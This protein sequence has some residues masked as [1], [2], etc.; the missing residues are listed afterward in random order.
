M[1]ESAIPDT[2][3]DLTAWSER[4]D[5]GAFR[6]LVEGHADMVIAV[7]RRR[8]GNA[9]A[10]DDAAQA[11]FI[12]LA[13]RAQRIRDSASLDGWLY[14]AAIGVCRNARR[15]AARRTRH[16]R[17]AAH[18][19]HQQVTA[20]R[21]AAPIDWSEFRPRLDE[22]MT[23]LNTIE[24]S[25]VIGHFLL[26]Q[27]QAVV[28]ERH[29]LSE[30]AVRRRIDTALDK[31][32]LWF[33]RRELRIGT[34]MLALCLASE[35]RSAEPTL[36]E[37]CVQAGLRP[38]TASGASALASGTVANLGS[39]ALAAA[40][41][42]TVATA[43]LVGASRHQP[44]PAD[45]QPPAAMAEPAQ[46]RLRV[47]WGGAAAPRWV[48]HA[49]DDAVAAVRTE[50]GAPRTD[51]VS[52]KTRSDSR[53]GLAWKDGLQFQFDIALSVP[54]I[55]T[56]IVVLCDD[57]GDWRMN[58]VHRNE[59]PA[60]RTGELSVRSEDFTPLNRQRNGQPEPLFIQNIAIHTDT[61]DLRLHAARIVEVVEPDNHEP[62]GH[63][64]P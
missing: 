26:G 50:D 39:I 44:E 63:T 1:V 12:L 40:A 8:L 64:T 31:L 32:R 7:C 47:L 41:V 27:S 29:G 6:R 4:H 14:Q 10:A 35:A 60:G 53:I 56:V 16:E 3:H 5:H 61:A 30:S 24:R 23:C 15:A 2:A 36:T 62:A 9:A 11:V 25:A 22:A 19:M 57:R 43:A 51:I 33:T 37:S 13:R 58:M 45:I 46:Q 49:N 59:L 21:S 52:V 28:A 48:G 42:L 38:E 34:G 54:R 20:D 55:I 17:K 18:A